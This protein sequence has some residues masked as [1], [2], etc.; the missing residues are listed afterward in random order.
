MAHDVW[1]DVS[2]GGGNAASAGTGEDR[3]WA[4]GTAGCGQ[5]MLLNIR[6]SCAVRTAL[7]PKHID[8]GI[9]VQNL[10]CFI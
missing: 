6:L 8:G 1:Y 5:C 4:Q 9:K 10:Q 2:L 3:R 7:Y